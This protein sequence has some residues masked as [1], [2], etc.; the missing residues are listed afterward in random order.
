MPLESA[1]DVP[2]HRLT[3]FSDAVV[4]I[5]ITLLVLPLLDLV[6]EAI[7][8]DEEPVAVVTHNLLPIGSFLLSF[9]VVWRLW[10]V[11]H[12]VFRSSERIG[13]FVSFVNM[14]WLACIV[15]L[16]FAVALIGAYGA[17]PFVLAVYVGLLLVSSIALTTMALTLRRGHDSL[18]A[19]ER[20]VVG[21]L[22]GNATC[23]AVAFI[24]VL[25][26]PGTGFWPLLLL[27]LDG[28][29]LAVVRRLRRPR[30]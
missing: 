30:R 16:P 14:L 13:G 4:A 15:L 17:E 27:L 2:S 19:P 1:N 25:A 28:P 8:D 18:A 22:G 5:S 21:R 9:V 7:R 11:H 3:G 23:L 26:F 6:A 29:V 20:A 10:S 24:I 12:Q